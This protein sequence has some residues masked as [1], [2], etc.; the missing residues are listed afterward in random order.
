MSSGNLS[1]PK[2]KSRWSVARQKQVNLF[3]SRLHINMYSIKE[4]VVESIIVASR[5]V[6]PAEF[7]SMLGGKNKV[8]EELVVL[9]AEFGQD[10]STIRFDLAPFDKSI[11]GTVHSH[12]NENNNPS[13][14]DLDTF[15]R[16]GQVHIIIGYP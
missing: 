9:P 16:T 14:A 4:G 1:W 7:I 11:M 13:R 2:K 10:F 6:Y 12:P 5:N 8:I 15:R 3:A